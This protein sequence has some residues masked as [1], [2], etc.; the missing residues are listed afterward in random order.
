MTIQNIV[1][2]L[3][4]LPEHQLAE[5]FKLI[6]SMNDSDIPSRKSTF[7][8]IMSYHGAFGN[9]N[10]KDYT[11]FLNY[12]SASRDSLFNRKIEI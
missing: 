1:S 11:D 6:K 2:E 3:N 7:D 9:M 5:I 10:D 8:E 4:K 12:I